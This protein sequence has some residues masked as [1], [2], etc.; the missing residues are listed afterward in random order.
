MPYQYCLYP[1]QK[2]PGAKNHMVVT[3]RQSK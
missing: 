1:D 2:P 3:T